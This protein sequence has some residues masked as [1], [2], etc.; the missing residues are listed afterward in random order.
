MLLLHDRFKFIH[1]DFNNDFLQ[2]NVL[3]WYIMSS[4]TSGKILI[5]SSKKISMY[6]THT[7]GK[8]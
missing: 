7:M 5:E 4:S 3:V 8:R 6:K 2:L 1:K